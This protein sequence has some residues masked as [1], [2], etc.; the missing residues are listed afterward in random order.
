MSQY[1]PEKAAKTRF[2]EFVGQK[3]R[4]I[5]FV[6]KVRPRPIKHECLIVI[7]DG[8]NFVSNPIRGSKFL[9]GSNNYMCLFSKYFLSADK[10]F[11]DLRRF[12]HG[13][14][15]QLRRKWYTFG[16]YFSFFT[17]NPIWELETSLCVLC[18]TFKE[19]CCSTLC[20]FD[21]GFPVFSPTPL[22]VHNIL[23][24]MGK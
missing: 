19:K 10:L 16:W 8:W 20:I 13:T 4:K 17:S 3:R 5:N 7:G 11:F 6:T 23:A 15:N 18:N 12:G 1:C 2:N 9:S 22:V 24:M 21:S 14:Q